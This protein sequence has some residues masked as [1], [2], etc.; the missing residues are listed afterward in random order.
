VLL[1]DSQTGELRWKLR[2]D[3][4]QLP[5]PPED[6]EYC[7]FLDS[8]F[9]ARLQEMTGAEF[10]EQ[11]EDSFSGFLRLSE[12]EAVSARNLPGLLDRLFAQFVQTRVI[13]FET[14]L[15]L[16]RL[17]AAATKFGEDSEVSESEGDVEWVLAPPGLRL[18]PEL[19]VVQ[20]VGRSMEPLIPDGSLVVFR[21]IAPGTRQGKRLLIEELGA[22]GSSARFTVKRYTSVKKQSSEDEWAHGVIRLEPLNPEFPAFEL[23]PEAFEGKYRVIGE[24][25]QVLETE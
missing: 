15:P 20:V 17:R 11:I 23:D 22:T 16:Y 2:T 1:L 19:F 5:I 9:R 18:S 10:L 21:K 3:L 24:F 12:R 8:D 25:V 14:H 4:D 13:R 7:S 6:A